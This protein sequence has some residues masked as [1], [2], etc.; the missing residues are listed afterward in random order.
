MQS[1]INSLQGHCHLQLQRS[2]SVAKEGGG[3]VTWRH[4]DNGGDLSAVAV[5][6][7]T[8]DIVTCSASIVATAAKEGVKL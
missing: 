2:F 6:L 5:K 3:T 8:G 1:Q 7:V 4:A